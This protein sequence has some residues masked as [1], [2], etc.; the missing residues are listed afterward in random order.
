MGDKNETVSFSGML[1]PSRIARW[2]ECQQRTKFIYIDGLKAPPFAA[3]KYGTAWDLF[4]THQE[5]G[6]F[7]LK[8]KEGHSLSP[9]QSANLFARFWDEKQEEV[10]DWKDDK[11]GKLLDIGV[12]AA[13]KW[14]KEVGDKFLATS[15]QKKFQLL[16]G[17]GTWG[18]R[19][20]LDLVLVGEPGKADP[21]PVIHD[22]KT[23]GKSWSARKLAQQLQPAAYT[24]AAK[25][26]PG[27]KKLGASEDKFVFDVHVKTK[28]PKI[29]QLEVDVTEA[30][31]NGFLKMLRNTRAQ[32]AF[33]EKEGVF[34]PNRD[35]ML[36][37]RKW[38]PF[39]R[40]CEKEWGGKVP[41]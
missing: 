31:Q 18:Y 6:F 8:N 25:H 27:L 23:S 9:S 10:E 15:I 3:L 36:C 39:W 38:C 29:Q 1:S 30:D 13:R 4:Q 17:D 21:N 32:M 35:S 7:V 11:P 28:E 34:L 2:R 19:G 5:E 14:T 22:A 33:A 24:L 26:E 12:E 41:E 20:I 40:E 16:L 37:S